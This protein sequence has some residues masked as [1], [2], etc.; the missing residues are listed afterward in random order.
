V[1]ERERPVIVEVAAVAV[2]TLRYEDYLDHSRGEVFR[3][4]C[5]RSGPKIGLGAGGVDSVAG[6]RRRVALTASAGGGSWRWL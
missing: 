5:T 3:G 6:A 2:S 1:P 4:A